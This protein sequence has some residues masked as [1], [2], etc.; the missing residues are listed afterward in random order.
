MCIFHLLLS[1]LWK[2]RFNDQFFLGRVFCS[3][4]TCCFDF[5][6]W[7][8][9]MRPAIQICNGGLYS[10]FWEWGK[11]PEKHPIRELY[12]V[13]KLVGQMPW[14]LYQL[15]KHFFF[16]WSVLKNTLSR[17]VLKTNCKLTWKHLW[18]RVYSIFNE[19]LPYRQWF[20]TKKGETLRYMTNS[21]W[22]W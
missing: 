20:Y 5:F 16:W 21:S 13:T 4:L 11:H 14:H 6:F 10:W 22:L 17:G 7:E 18:P 1:N 15:T 12:G 19:T 3:N 8:K 2:T 9:K